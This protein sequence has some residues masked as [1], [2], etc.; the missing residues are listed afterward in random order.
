M[1]SGFQVIRLGGEST[2][3]KRMDAIKETAARD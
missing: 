2:E 1:L 3:P